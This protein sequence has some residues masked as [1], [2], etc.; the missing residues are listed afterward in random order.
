MERSNSPW[1]I[2]I[3]VICLNS[4]AIAGG[5]ASGFTALACLCFSDIFRVAACRYPVTNLSSMADSTHRFEAYYMDYLLGDIS[6]S[7]Y[8]DRSPINN[9]EKVNCPVIFFQGMQDK[10][11]PPSQALRMQEALLEN[12]IPCD[13]YL[14]E[15]EGHGFRDGRNKIDVLS[16]TEEFFK[17]HLLL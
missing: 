6:S 3:F 2:W 17:K 13:L 1:K 7:K 8:I 11:V 4:I 10:V 15:N 12:D 5:S 9:V 14:Y 16:K